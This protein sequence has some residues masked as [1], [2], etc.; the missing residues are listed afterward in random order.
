M[1]SE[2]L[3]HTWRIG[4]TP[5]PIV[6]VFGVFRPVNS[7][8]IFDR[9]YAKTYWSSMKI[10]RLNATFMDTRLVKN[11]IYIFDLVFALFSLD[12]FKGF[13]F[14]HDFIYYGKSPSKKTSHHLCVYVWIPSLKLT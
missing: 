3:K 8:I 13:F 5:P 1:V 9:T 10:F 4:K 6:E 12:S 7:P 11:D 2:V 14:L